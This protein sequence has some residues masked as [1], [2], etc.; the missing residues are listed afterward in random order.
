MTSQFPILTQGSGAGD[1]CQHTGCLSYSRTWRPYPV[2][3][4][5]VAVAFL[6]REGLVAAA[7]KAVEVAAARLRSAP[8][9]KK[10][11]IPRP[12]EPDEML[13]LQPGDWVE[14]KSEAEIRATLDGGGKHRG[15]AFVPAEMLI[16]CGRRYRVY[17]RVE[18]IFL[19]E[20]RQNRKL[21]NTVLLDGVQCQ[22]IGLECDRCC[23]LFWREAWLKKADQP[24][25]SVN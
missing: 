10:P 22:G 25:E 16:H 4:A 7:R 14:V 11:A 9:E 24:M 12:Y 21:K 3:M 23:Y 5:R 20:S 8:A 1:P 19:E 18:K 6:R 13:G 15:M 2:F 17:K